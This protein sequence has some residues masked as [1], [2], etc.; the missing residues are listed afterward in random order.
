MAARLLTAEHSKQGLGGKPSYTNDGLD[1]SNKDAKTYELGYMATPY[2]RSRPVNVLPHFVC[3]GAGWQGRGRGLFC[4]SQDAGE[5]R[6]FQ[7]RLQS[8]VLII[9]RSGAQPTSRLPADSL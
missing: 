7:S 4:G 6:L 9:A 8:V 3:G 1:R 2:Y 5:H